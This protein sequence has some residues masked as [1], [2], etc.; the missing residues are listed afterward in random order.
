MAQNGTDWKPNQK[1]KKIVLLM[2]DIDDKRKLK[3]KLEEAEVPRRTFYNWMADDR[4]KSY[5]EKELRTFTDA[6]EH[7][8]WKALIKNINRGETQAIKLFFELKGKYTQKVS[9][10]KLEDLIK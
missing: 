4:F 6:E 8:A 7:N 10:E 3:D 9:V 5:L 1:Q 2:L